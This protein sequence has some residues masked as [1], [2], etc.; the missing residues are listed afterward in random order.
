[1]KPTIESLLKKKHP[2]TE[3]ERRVLS[4]ERPA[5]AYALWRVQEHGKLFA[6]E[7]EGAEDSGGYQS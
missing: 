2:L 1:M 7:P 4:E 6:T 5:L 3:E